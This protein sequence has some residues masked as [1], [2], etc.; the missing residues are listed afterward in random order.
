[1]RRP[2]IVGNW[3][4]NKTASEAVAFIRDFRERVAASPHAEV[5]LAPAFTALESARNAL[6]PSSWIGLG[7]QNVHWETHGS[8]T[9]EVSAP[10]LRELDCRY[11]IVGHSDRRTL[12]GERDETIQKK[13]QA[14]LR[15]G[16]SPIL[17]VGESLAER[18]TGLTESVVT[19]QLNG[20][21]AGLSPQDLA[22]VTIA[23][24]PVWAI[25]TGRAATTEQAVTVHRSIRL[26]VETGWDN[27]TASV[28]RILYGGSVTP[29]NI[30]P[31]LAS[32]A[33]DGALV[34]GACLSPDSFARIVRSAQIQRV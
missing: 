19:A 7:A 12:F 9:G 27:D 18:E 20:G 16:L 5:V 28:V 15:H 34:G 17:C 25:G 14:A 10:M 1:M 29:Q 23:Y 3:K 2:L 30:E 26:F 6:G 8:F 33:I 4:M 24:E 11:V 13:V 32:D 22:T 31:L 21:L